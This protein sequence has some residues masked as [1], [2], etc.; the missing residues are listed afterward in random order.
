MKSEEPLDNEVDVYRKPTDGGYEM[1][2]TVQGAE[3]VVSGVIAGFEFGLAEAL[4]E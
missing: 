4:V 3:K 1:M 2:E